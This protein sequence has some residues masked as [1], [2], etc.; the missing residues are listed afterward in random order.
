[1]GYFPIVLEQT[2]TYGGLLDSFIIQG[3]TFDRFVHLSF[4]NVGDQNN[5]TIPEKPICR[6][7]GI[8]LMDGLCVK[9]QSSSWLLNK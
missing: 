4:T 1:M 8:E 7:L 2:G 5:Y 6:E 3:F 9:I